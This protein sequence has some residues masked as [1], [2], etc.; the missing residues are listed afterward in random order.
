MPSPTGDVLETYKQ[1]TVPQIPQVNKNY[2]TSSQI[3]PKSKTAGFQAILATASL[4]P[5]AF[6]SILINSVT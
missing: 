5:N 2:S 6:Y 1:A 3:F 4:T